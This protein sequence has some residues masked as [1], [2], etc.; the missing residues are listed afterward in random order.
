MLT[1][2]NLGACRYATT[3]STSLTS[4]LVV[5]TLVSAA[6]AKDEWSGREDGYDGAASWG[7][8]NTDGAATEQA[9]TVAIGPNHALPIEHCNNW[10]AWHLPMP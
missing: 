3:K 8:I 5:D 4:A 10:S 6:D 9:V 2:D 7:A 1:V